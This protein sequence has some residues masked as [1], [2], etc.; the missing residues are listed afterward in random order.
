MIDARYYVPFRFDI[1]KTVVNTVALLIMSVLVI[2]A[3]KLYML[4]MVLLFALI[5]FINYRAIIDTAKK[6]L[7][8]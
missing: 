8:R 6:L 1:V 5:M 3:P 7:K 4:W 2:G